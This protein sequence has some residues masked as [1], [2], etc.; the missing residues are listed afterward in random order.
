MGRRLVTSIVRVASQS[1]ATERLRLGHGIEADATPGDED[2]EEGVRRTKRQK[3]HDSNLRRL[4]AKFHALG[5]PRPHGDSGRGESRFRTRALVAFALFGWPALAGAQPLDAPISGDLSRLSNAQLEQ[6]IQFLR[7][8]FR[9]GERHARYWQTGFTLAWATG[10]A[11][12]TVQASL[13]S[14]PDNRVAAVVTATK[15]AIGTTKLLLSPNPAR[16][17]DAPLSVQGPDAR[18]TLEARLVA[19]E[20]QLLAI[21]HKARERTSWTAHAA[22]LGLNAA[23]GGIIVALGNP[24][25]AIQNAGVGVL[26]GEVMLWSMPRR[27]IDDLAEYRALVATGVRRPLRPGVSLS[28]GA[29]WRRGLLRIRF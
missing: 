22:N 7:G 18:T 12:G 13:S 2:E 20:R 6:R 3:R 27:G 15:A 5:C 19:G 14:E 9:A 23:G 16:L 26:F 24:S 21:D 4:G 28:I 11:L 29:A 10:A 1:G 17:G 8:R 25:D